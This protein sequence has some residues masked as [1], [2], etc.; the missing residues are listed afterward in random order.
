[1]KC[2]QKNWRVFEFEES[3]RQRSR[4]GDNVRCFCV[5]FFPLFLFVKFCAASLLLFFFAIFARY[6]AVLA[7]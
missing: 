6:C 4:S 3:S 5:C 1:M 2:I 7:P